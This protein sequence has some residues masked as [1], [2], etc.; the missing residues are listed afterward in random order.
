MS[1]I[2]SSVLMKN[3]LPFMFNSDL[4]NGFSFNKG[5]YLG[6]EIVAR[7]YFTGIV[8][9]RVFP[10]LLENSSEKIKEGEILYGEGNKEIGK[11]IESLDGCG[12]VLVQYLPLM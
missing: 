10:F 8:R 3:K 11:V 6:Q 4:F 2:S 7:A 12:T 1:G 9:R 5:C